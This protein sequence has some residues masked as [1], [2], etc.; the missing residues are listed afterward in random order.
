MDCWEWNI[1]DFPITIGNSNPPC[2]INADCCYRILPPNGPLQIFI[3]ELNVSAASQGNKPTPQ[4]MALPYYNPNIPYP[5]S[6]IAGSPWDSSFESAIWLAIFQILRNKDAKNSNIIPNYASV[7]P[8]KKPVEIYFHTQCSG[9]EN[10]GGTPVACLNSS[11]YCKISCQ[12]CKTIYG[13]ILV[14]DPVYTPLLG[15]GD[16]ND[17]KPALPFTSNNATCHSS[18]CTPPSVDIGGRAI[19][20]GRGGRGLLLQRVGG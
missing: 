16:P 11:A 12:I 17:C 10:Q 14:R 3:K 15:V 4:C 18:G 19:S 20:V 13:Q 9:T 5:I 2:M 8:T 6:S 7:C 1:T